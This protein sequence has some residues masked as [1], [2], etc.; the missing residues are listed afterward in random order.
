MRPRTRKSRALARAGVSESFCGPCGPS[1]LGDAHHGLARSTLEVAAH[2][3]GFVK[4]ASQAW[5]NSHG[6]RVELIPHLPD[7]VS[8]VPCSPGV[9]KQRCLQPTYKHAEETVRNIMRHLRAQRRVAGKAIQ[10]DMFHPLLVACKVQRNNQCVKGWLLNR[11]SFS[12]LAADADEVC[13]HGDITCC[14]DIQLRIRFEGRHYGH[15][16]NEPLPSM[17]S[18]PELLLWMSKHQELSFMRANYSLVGHGIIRV[19]SLLPCTDDIAG[20]KADDDGGGDDDDEEFA[21]GRAAAKALKL[22]TRV[23]CPA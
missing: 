17:W 19:D 7:A 5:V 2:T 15:A 8:P 4:L 18:S 21:G 3:S 12:P 13:P 9:C 16:L 23:A 11:T 22:L 14:T 1:G 6:S 10:Q 20:D